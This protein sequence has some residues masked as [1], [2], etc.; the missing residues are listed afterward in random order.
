MSVCHSLGHFIIGNKMPEYRHAD[1][2]RYRKRDVVQD[3]EARRHDGY[4]ALCEK[5]GY[6]ATIIR[7]L[8]FLEAAEKFVSSESDQSST[9]YIAASI[10]ESM[11]I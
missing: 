4:L 1:F 8:L 10:N 5:S 7:K 3:A 2:K 6:R 9:T 11:S